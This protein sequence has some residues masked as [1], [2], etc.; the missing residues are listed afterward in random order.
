M[1]EAHMVSLSQLTPHTLPRPLTMK[2]PE[3]LTLSYSLCLCF[4]VI[5]A[6]S[7]HT[8]VVTSDG[9]ILVMGGVV[10][11]RSSSEVWSSIDGSSWTLLT[12]TAWGTDGGKYFLISHPRHRLSNCSII[13]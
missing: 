6:R 9:S 5:V 11:S 1:Y 8:S 10:E 12:S 3:I 7:D 13:K 4:H 2:V